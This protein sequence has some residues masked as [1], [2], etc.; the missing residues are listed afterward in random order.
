MRK[1]TMI[2]LLCCLA[3]ASPAYADVGVVGVEPSSA[4][5]GLNLGGYDFEY[6]ARD[7]EAVIYGYT[8]NAQ[9]L[10]IYGSYFGYRTNLDEC[11]NGISGSVKA[12][13]F[14]EGIETVNP[15]IFEGSNVQKVYFP[16]SM[17]S[18][19]DTTLS[20]LHPDEDFVEIFFEGTADEWSRIFNRYQDM[21]FAEAESEEDN[22]RT[23]S[24][25]LNSLLGSGYDSSEY[26][27]NFEATP[28]DLLKSMGETV[29]KKK[30]KDDEAEEETEEED[31]EEY[32]NYAAYWG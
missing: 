31:K 2:S 1:T 32:E 9:I 5:S 28:D 18:I 24:N 27:Y 10:K 14:G 6:G 7:H 22:A 8:G 11:E 16:L 17:R 19:E 30:D 21:S 23:A 15:A 4:S 26:Q 3:L 29:K 25:W 12:V 13:I 20:Y